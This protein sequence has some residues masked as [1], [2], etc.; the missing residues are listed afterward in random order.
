MVQLLTLYTDPECHNAQHY[1]WT[2]RRKDNIIENMADVADKA[3]F[4]K[5]VVERQSLHG[6][7]PTKRA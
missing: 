3:L 6:L 7:L 2:D 1:R 4:E 5:I